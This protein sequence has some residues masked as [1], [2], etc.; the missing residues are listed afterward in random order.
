RPTCPASWPDWA[1]TGWLPECSRL[2]EPRP[3]RQA[4][5]ACSQRFT[6][7]QFHRGSSSRSPPVVDIERRVA[8]RCQIA[9]TSRH[10]RPNREDGI[11]HRMAQRGR[12]VVVTSAVRG[13]GS[14]ASR[15]GVRSWKLWSLPRNAL[16]FILTVELLAV[17]LT[18]VAVANAHPTKT[19]V[20]RFAL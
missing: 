6:A 17:G 3:A 18:A 8:G 19:D 20:A 2:G 11:H 14:D 15:Q 7:T 9:P 1:A 13:S 12:P 10:R 16:A 5:A 4:Q